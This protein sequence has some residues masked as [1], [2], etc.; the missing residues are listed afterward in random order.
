[1][2]AIWRD[3][4][5][6]TASIANGGTTSGEI[7]LKHFVLLGVALPA[8]FTGASLTFLVAEQ[9]GGTFQPLYDDT[10]AQVTLG[11]AAGR[12]YTLPAALAAW[13]VC[14]LVSSAAEG[15]ARTL[16]LVTKG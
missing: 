14:K 13:P 10:G 6:V 3:Q 9:P 7:L 2:S 15:G 12:S 4:S 8:A 5:L 11:V 16:T 1:M